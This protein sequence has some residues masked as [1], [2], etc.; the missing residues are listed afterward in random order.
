MAKDSGLQQPILAAVKKLMADG[1]YDKIFDY[2]GLT[3]AKID[4][5]TINGAID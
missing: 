2:W 4:N 3:T 5:P 1:T